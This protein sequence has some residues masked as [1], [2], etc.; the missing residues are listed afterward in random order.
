MTA[1]LAAACVR[2]H[3]LYADADDFPSA[4]PGWMIAFVCLDAFMLLS[5]LAL[6]VAQASQ[7]QGRNFSLNDAN[8]PL[9]IHQPACY[10]N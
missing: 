10:I 8:I 3:S 4:G 1:A 5:V 2:I 6:A 9:P 7:V